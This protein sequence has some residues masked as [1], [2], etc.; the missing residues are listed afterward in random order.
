MNE[1]REL[2]RVAKML[3]AARPIRLDKAMIKREAE[4][5]AEKIWRL[6]KDRPW[7]EGIGKLV[8]NFELTITNVAGE[9][10]P[11]IVVVKSKE[12]GRPPNPRRLSVR[13]VVTGGGAGTAKGKP[14]ILMN[15]NANYYPRHFSPD[16]FLER[17][18]YEMML[19]ELT[20][21]SDKYKKKKPT[22]QR[23]RTV[24]EIDPVEY[25]NDPGE[26]KAYMQEVVE[27]VRRYFPKIYKHRGRK[28]AM[29]FSLKMSSTWNMIEPHLNRRNRNKILSAVWNEVQDLLAQ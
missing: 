19:H 11:V 29:K 23:V 8:L 24:E 26:V 25:Y 7:E 28:D 9:M 21:I 4:Q 16:S 12:V 13:D 27:Q 14:A 17:E 6:V 10:I 22:T 20:H 2:L 1:A 18:L 15:V 3:F 5:L